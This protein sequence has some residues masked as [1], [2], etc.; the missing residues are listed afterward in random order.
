METYDSMSD[1]EL[2]ALI[3]ADDGPAFAELYERYFGV[4]YLH[5]LKKLRDKDEA[6]DL[7]QELFVVLWD[8]RA[9]LSSYRQVSGYLFACVR[10]RVLNLISRKKTQDKYVLTLP[11]SVNFEAVTDHRV[12]ERQLAAII[13]AEVQSLP[14]RMR[15][16]FEMSRKQHFSHQEIAVTL[17]LSE[18]SVRSHVKGALRILRARLGLFAYILF[19][20][21]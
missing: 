1:C 14:P 7:V 6:K 18:Q 20:L 21:K 2:A 19:L 10:N 17:G 13:E 5:A 9:N 11:A 8:R 4:L 12:R 3:S 16:V 15:E